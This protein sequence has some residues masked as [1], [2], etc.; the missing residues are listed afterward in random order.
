MYLL[1][2]TSYDYVELL[3]LIFCFDNF[4]WMIPYS[5]DMDPPMC[6]LML[7]YIEYYA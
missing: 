2:P 5:I 3:T 6:I 1:I 4:L 7:S